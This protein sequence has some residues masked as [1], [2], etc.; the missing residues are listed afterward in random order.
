MGPRLDPALSGDHIKYYLKSGQRTP[1]SCAQQCI[2]ETTLALRAVAG[3]GP[4]CKEN[5]TNIIAKY[6]LKVQCLDS[7]AYLSKTHCP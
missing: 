5:I 7:V 4:F 3:D 6:Y 2:M 1:T